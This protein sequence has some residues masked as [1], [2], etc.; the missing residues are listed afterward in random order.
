MAAMTEASITSS[1]S[2]DGT[3]HVVVAGEVDMESSPRLATALTQAI[4][5]D[6][7]KCVV[8][9]LDG[10]SFLDSSGIRELVL[11]QM[12]ATEKGVTFYITNVHDAPRRVLELTAVFAVLTEQAPPA[13]ADDRTV[14]EEQ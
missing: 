5:A 1:A 11:A 3:V 10:V 8:V 7:T 2:A 4:H 6:D 9:D 14:G 13:A 12:L